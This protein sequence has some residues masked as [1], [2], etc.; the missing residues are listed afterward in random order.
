M[1]HKSESLGRRDQTKNLFCKRRRKGQ[2]ARETEVWGER[3]HERD[4]CVCVCVCTRL[5]GTIFPASLVLGFGKLLHKENYLSLLLS[6][7]YAGG[8]QEGT[9]TSVSWEKWGE[10][11]Y[12][13]LGRCTKYNA[14]NLPIGNVKG[15]RGQGEGYLRRGATVERGRIPGRV[16]DRMARYGRERGAYVRNRD[17]RVTMTRGQWPNCPILESYEWK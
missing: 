17:N 1:V 7:Y 3:C 10:A 6:S 16:L 12:D 9:T 2:K 8:G 15:R 5:N 13:F 4:L 11:D 14:R